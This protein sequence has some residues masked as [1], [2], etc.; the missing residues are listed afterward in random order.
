MKRGK[1]LKRSSKPLKRTP[2]RRSR[3]KSKEQQ[4]ED[5]YARDK[6]NMFWAYC[7]A[8]LGRKSIVSGDFI[9][10][11]GKINYHHCFEK[12]SNPE[13]KYA[14]SNIAVVTA[15][16]HQHLNNNLDYYEVVAEKR[17]WIREHW[18]ECM[19]ESGAWSEEYDK[20]MN[21]KKEEI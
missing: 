18:E 14:I 20:I 15:G 21:I 12:G 16:E 3:P 17:D 13:L 8:N 1:P 4:A 19:E 6:L 7:A 5:T 11:P 9:H 10:L 2:L